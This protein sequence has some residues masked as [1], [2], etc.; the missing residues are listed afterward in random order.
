MKGIEPRAL[1]FKDLI[2]AFHATINLL[3]IYRVKF[4]LIAA[5]LLAVAF[6]CVNTIAS[7]LVAIFVFF[8]PI[9]LLLF[10]INADDGSKISTSEIVKYIFT[11]SF[12]QVCYLSTLVALGAFLALAPELVIKIAK[13]L[14]PFSIDNSNSEIN[15]NRFVYGMALFI[16]AFMWSI[17]SR[18]MRLYLM[19]RFSLNKEDARNIY[20]NYLG[21]IDPV[22]YAISNTSGIMLALFAS[23]WPFMFPFW[24]IFFVVYEYFLLK[25]IFEG[26]AKVSLSVLN[27]TKTV[28]SGVAA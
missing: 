21:I 23:V 13:S 16:A 9:F 11:L 26:G 17:S 12:W 20:R 25:A 2:D 8:G 4:S 15:L 28:D 27:R 14:V 1:E 24:M 10:S 19:V 22:V 7:S 3:N 18:I 6:I 5:L